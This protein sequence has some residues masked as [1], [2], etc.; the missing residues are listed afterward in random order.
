MSHH[1]FFR[2]LLA[3][4]VVFSV[5]SAEASVMLITNEGGI[6]ADG[7]I[8]WG[9]LGPDFTE[10]A[11]PFNLPVPGIPG[12]N[13][14]VS[15]DGNSNFE[16]RDQGTGWAGNFAPGE[17]LLWT[18]GFNGPMSLDFDSPI[19]GFGSQIQR[20]Q[21][22]AFTANISAF[23]GMTLLGSFDLNGVSTSAGDD[24]AIFLGILSD[25]GDITR[26]VLDI[27]STDDFAI[28][29][30]RIQRAPEPASLGLF[31]LGVLCLGIARRRR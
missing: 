1:K 17:E 6:D 19:Q 26:I 28:N 18:N 7:L 5:A 31:G 30:P 8:D 9:V 20:N 27:S 13:V 24:S 22:G 23:N 11:Q 3:V 10:I 16:R 15:Q 25:S 12:L 14:T 4:L 21:F 29:G 2:L